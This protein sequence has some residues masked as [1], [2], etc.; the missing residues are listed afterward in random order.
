MIDF[1][2]WLMAVLPAVSLLFVGIQI[3][4]KMPL[5]RAGMRELI[6]AAAVSWYGKKK[7]KLIEE[8]Q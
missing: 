8:K 5:P 3:L 4:P 2:S 7:V 6:V 1:Y